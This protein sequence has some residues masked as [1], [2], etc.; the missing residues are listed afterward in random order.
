ML[1]LNHKRRVLRV[2]GFTL[3]EA[4]VVLSIVIILAAVV[5]P[6]MSGFIFDS[7]VSANVNEYIGA[8]TLARTEAVKRGTLVTM[9]ISNNADTPDAACSAGGDW[10]AGW[11]IFQESSTSDS[12]G[13]REAGEGIILRR[14]ALMAG[15]KASS[16]PSTSVMSFNSL[17]EP[18]GVG[19]TILAIDFSDKD[20]NPRKVCINRNG[21]IRVMQKS[22][23]G[24]DCL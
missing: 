16:N 19:G 5:I 13:S 14:G 17:G 20:N 9:C 2:S 7:R 23:P 24:V 1:L 21:R 12:V 8:V 4:I 6:G 15:V 11:I 18:V 3:I 22:G 10:A